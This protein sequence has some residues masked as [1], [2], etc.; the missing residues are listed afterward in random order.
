MVGQVADRVMVLHRGRIAAQGAA[1]EVL[2]DPQD[3]HTR[4]L[5]AALP[6]PDPVRRSRRRD[7]AGDLFD[8]LDAL[9]EGVAS[10]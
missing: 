10:P 3:D 1:A 2:G 8:A 7:R 5:V 9:D 4:R 6:V